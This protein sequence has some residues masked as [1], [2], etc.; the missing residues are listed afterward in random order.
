MARV[1]TT[2]MPLYVSEADDATLKHSP[3]GTMRVVSG[4]GGVG[5]AVHAARSK[6]GEGGPVESLRAA[7]EISVG[8]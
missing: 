7:R 4:V 5:S 2:W 1:P 8:P 6:V 3:S